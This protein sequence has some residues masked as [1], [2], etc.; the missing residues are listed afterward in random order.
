MDKIIEVIEAKKICETDAEGGSVAVGT[1]DFKA[2][3]PNG[4]GDG[5]VTVSLFK[6][7]ELEAVE[8]AVAEIKERKEYPIGLNFNTSIK[9]D[10][11]IYSAD[12]GD[13]ADTVAYKLSG[14]YGVYSYTSSY[15]THGYV[16]FEEW[17]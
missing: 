3:M 9:G 13:Y 4:Y 15:T 7:G 11:N 6:R 10:F 16:I 14:R 12:C 8:K 2:M 5:S 1:D 17:S